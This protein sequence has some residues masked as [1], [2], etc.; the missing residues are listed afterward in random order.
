MPLWSLCTNLSLVILSSSPDNT[1]VAFRQPAVPLRC[2]GRRWE[3]GK[4]GEVL[5]QL[6]VEK[7]TG[8]PSFHRR[9]VL[10]TQK[11]SQN[12]TGLIAC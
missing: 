6:R 9:P 5:S 4:K 7:E 10:G 8:P 2:G 11:L 1:D 3:T 12:V